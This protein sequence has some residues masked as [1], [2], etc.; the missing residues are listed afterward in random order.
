MRHRPALAM[1]IALT[2]LVAS[3]TGVATANPSPTGSAPST[4]RGPRAHEDHAVLKVPRGFEERRV[5]RAPSQRSN[6]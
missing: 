5:R 2:A 4:L 6:W 3:I 1:A